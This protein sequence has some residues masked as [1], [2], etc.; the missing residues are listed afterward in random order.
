MFKTKNHKK[1]LFE[2]TEKLEIVLIFNVHK[3][4]R[5]KNVSI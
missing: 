2:T 4:N 3:P 1:P 5:R